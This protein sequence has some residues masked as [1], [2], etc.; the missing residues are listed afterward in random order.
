MRRTA[1]LAGTAL[2]AVLMAG[3]AGGGGDKADD[4]TASATPSAAPRPSAA[5]GKGGPLDGAYAARSADGPV[6][7]SL[8]GDKAAVYSDN[9]KRA[10]V[11]SFHRDAK[12]ATLALRCADG[13]TDRAGGKVEPTGDKTLV[14]TW[15]SGTKDTFTRTADAAPLPD[16]TRLGGGLP[17]P[18]KLGDG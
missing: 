3:C 15:D 8:Y 12:P 4:R 6:G 10:C 13:N 5:T 9:G 16:P 1:Q 18:T 2:A 14:V 7:L 17:A 11:G